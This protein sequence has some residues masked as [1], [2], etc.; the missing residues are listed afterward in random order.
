MFP[1]VQKV[2]Q[3]MIYF[4][5]YKHEQFPDKKYFYSV[6]WTIFPDYMKD[7]IIG[8]HKKHNVDVKKEDNSVIYITP[9]IFEELKDVDFKSSK[10]VSSFYLNRD[11]GAYGLLA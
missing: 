10:I 6:M 7:V 1:K 3:L 2:E 9:Q 8:S 4:P 5:D 11:K